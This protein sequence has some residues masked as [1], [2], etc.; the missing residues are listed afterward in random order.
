M[1]KPLPEVVIPKESAVFF[2]DEHGKWRHKEQG[3]FEHRKI[4][5][6][7]HSCIRKDEKGY[8]LKQKLGDRIEKVYFHYEDTALFVFDVIKGEEIVLVLNT[9]KK[10]KLR[11]TKLFVIEDSLYVTSGEHRVKFTDNSLVRLWDL[12]GYEGDDY[13]ITVKGR[14]YKI[15]QV[16]KGTL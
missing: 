2:L 13:F 5:S 12:L 10:I 3:K 14:R 4:I 7:F 11:P 6:Y 9:Q 8:H 15:R 1:K 16:E